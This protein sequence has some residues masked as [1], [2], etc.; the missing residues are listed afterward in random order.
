MGGNVSLE[1]R[2]SDENHE[3]GGSAMLVLT[4]KS[5]ET[6]VIGGSADF[7]VILKLT[8]LKIKGGSVRLGFEGPACVPVHRLEV[9]EQRRA[10]RDRHPAKL[11]AEQARVLTASVGAL[12]GALGSDIEEPRTRRRSHIADYLDSLLQAAGPG[13]Q[14]RAGG[15]RRASLLGLQRLLGHCPTLQSLDD[16]MAASVPSDAG[17]RDFIDHDL[18]AGSDR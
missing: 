4:R 11:S 1:T 12:R 2:I 3:D 17:L 9:W 5:Q 8:V 7:P 15:V 6:V 14:R 13:E 10:G 18:E 16:D